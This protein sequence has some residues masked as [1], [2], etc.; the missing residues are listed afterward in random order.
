[1][2]SVAAGSLPQYPHLSPLPPN[3]ILINDVEESPWMPYTEDGTLNL[4]SRRWVLGS[5]YYLRFPTTES[6]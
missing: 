6:P 2:L 3:H 5:D 4:S 1:M